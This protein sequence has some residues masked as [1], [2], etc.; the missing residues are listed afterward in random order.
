[1]SFVNGKD[2]I[3]F[4]YTD[5]HL[6]NKFFLVI[7]EEMRRWKGWKEGKGERVKG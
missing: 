2:I 3:G 7:F 4:K 5:K 6:Y 1:L